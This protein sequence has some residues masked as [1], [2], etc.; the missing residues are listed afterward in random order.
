MSCTRENNTLILITHE[1][2]QN[3]A[4]DYSDSRRSDFLD[5]EI[6]VG[7]RGRKDLQN[8]RDKFIDRKQNT[9]FAVL[10]WF[11]LIDPRLKPI[12]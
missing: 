7:R 10:A 9:Y 11:L 12:I 3:T 4:R 5:E 1:R 2:P 6:F 8:Q